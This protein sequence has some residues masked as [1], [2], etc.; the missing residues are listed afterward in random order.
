MVIGLLIGLFLISTFGIPLPDVK[1]PAQLDS[2][3]ARVLMAFAGLVALLLIAAA[4][5]KAVEIRRARNWP[6]VPGRVV[7]SRRVVER[8]GDDA[9]GAPIEQQVARVEFQYEVGGKLYASRRITIGERVAGDGIEP[10]L[11]RYPV[12]T[13]V[14]VHY[15][16]RDP[17][18]G[19]VERAAPEGMLRGCLIA[20]ALGMASTMFLMRVVT[21]GPGFFMPAL[22]AALPEANLPA[23]L[24]FLAGAALV[25]IAAG[26]LARMTLKVRRWPVAPGEILSSGVR[27]GASRDDGGRLHRPVVRYRY[28]VGGRSYEGAAIEH[29]V[30]TSG[31]EG[32]ARR[33]IARYPVGARVDVRYDPADPTR[34]ALAARFGVLGWALLAVAGL[35]LAGALL[36]SGLV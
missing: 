11:A 13:T 32:W 28:A 34:S 12:G 2:T 7:S 6:A 29:G 18:N 31:G 14:M 26:A 33:V 27:E 36:A 17:A 5:A 19:I 30:A 23:L 9:G 3:A 8:Q 24:L 4:V 16:P 10:L 25:L 15:D 1:L 20:L 21:E 22:H 35:L